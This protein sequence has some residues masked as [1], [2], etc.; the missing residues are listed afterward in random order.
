MYQN[1]PPPPPP[2]LSKQP[3]QGS[4]SGAP[5]TAVSPVLVVSPST[6]GVNPKALRVIYVLVSI[7][8]LGGMGGVVLTR[9]LGA[10]P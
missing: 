8:L 6:G 2:T 9:C 4:S 7:F 5:A 10:Y 1:V 3:G